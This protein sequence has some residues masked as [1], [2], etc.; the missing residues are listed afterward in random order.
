MS[1]LRVMLTLALLATPA[2]SATP[3]PPHRV[4]GEFRPLELLAV[5]IDGAVLTDVTAYE[6]YAV[7]VASEAST[8]RLDGSAAY[9]RFR[10][11]RVEEGSF[12][13][14]QFES[15]SEFYPTAQGPAPSPLDDGHAP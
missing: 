14:E 10:A 15:L 3:C 12:G 13:R 8:K 2:G 1:P 6:G 9:V 11:D 4:V 7:T 5:R